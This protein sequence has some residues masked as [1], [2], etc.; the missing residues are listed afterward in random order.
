MDNKKTRI[1]KWEAYRQ[2]IESN[3]N[4]D[5]SIINS[6]KELKK[7]LKSIKLDVNEE[8]SKKGYYSQSD[9]KVINNNYL[10][11]SDQI[12][13]VLKIIEDNENV[14]NKNKIDEEYN[15]HKYDELLKSNFEEFIDNKDSLNI[16][17][18]NKET[19]ELKIN[20]ISIEETN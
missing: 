4:I 18:D 1:H 11:E 16:S 17:Q 2:D 15:S 9:D 8:Y 14:E 6:D 20:K 12:N 7:M 10:L 13:D 5:F 19:T 3:E